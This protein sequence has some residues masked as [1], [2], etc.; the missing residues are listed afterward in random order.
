MNV[1]VNN[2]FATVKACT[3]EEHQFLR[4]LLA[5]SYPGH[6]F[7]PRFKSGEW[8]G[9]KRFYAEGSRTFPTGFLPFVIQEAHSKHF[10][11]ETDDLRQVPPLQDPTR[12]PSLYP[13]LRPYQQ[14]ALTAVFGNTLQSDNQVLPWQR[15]VIKYPTA[16]GKTRIAAAMIDFIGKKTL[17]VIE[18]KELMYQTHHAFRSE[19]GASLGLLGDGHSET[20]GMI[21]FAMAQTVR[22]RLDELGDFLA[23]IECLLYDECQHLAS[24][25]YHQIA[26]KCPAP[27]RFGVS[28]TPLKRG[29][30]GDVY[31][32]GDTGDIIA[33]GDREAIQEHGYIAKP[34]VV[35]FTISDPQ[36]GRMTYKMAY[37]HGIVENDARNA[38]IVAIAQKLRAKGCTTLILVRHTAHGLHLQHRL[39]EVGL[40]VQYIQGSDATAKRQKA[41][42][43]I[44][45][46]CDVL[47]A[48]AILDEGV[49]APVLD[50]LIR[51]GGGQSY[52]KTLQQVGRVLRPKPGRN[53]VY[54]IDFK[55]VTQPYLMKHSAERIAAYEAE[56]FAITFPTKV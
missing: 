39:K 28:A 12:I 17:Y 7:M 54:V 19:T 52:I 22:A 33:E 38:M 56:G 31:L 10:R 23:S 46:T 41:L 13:K 2:V 29:D 1:A 34:K 53:E 6:A 18:R 9:T 24:G 48:T 36:L 11:V 8:D 47:I 15:G 16:S 4:T 51:A 45:K 21:T 44:G 42:Q 55:D 5:V 40:S 20:D 50:A 14:E 37:K 35:V 26:T 30:L 3:V 25:I 32:I 49:D 43:G 27:F